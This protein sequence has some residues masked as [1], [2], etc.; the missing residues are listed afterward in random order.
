MGYLG[1]SVVLR[2]TVITTITNP[3][4]LPDV[5]T[6]RDNN[7]TKKNQKPFSGLSQEI[8]IL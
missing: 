7:N 5:T 3:T 6:G 8:G 4:W 2:I 1:G